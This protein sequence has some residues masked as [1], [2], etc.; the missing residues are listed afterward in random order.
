MNGQTVLRVFWRIKLQYTALGRHYVASRVCTP[1]HFVLA[2]DALG[3]NRGELIARVLNRFHSPV[4]SHTNTLLFAHVTATYSKIF[5]A[6]RANRNGKRTTNERDNFWALAHARGRLCVCVFVMQSKHV[7][8]YV[9]PKTLYASRN[10][11]YLSS[12]SV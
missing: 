5:A 9:R 10:R 12:W 6:N 1:L 2:D 3:I 4:H 11:F 7:A 8:F